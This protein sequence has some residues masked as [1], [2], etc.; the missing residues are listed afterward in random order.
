MLSPLHPLDTA[1]GAVE[2]LALRR[3]RGRRDECAGLHHN[4]DS[5]VRVQGRHA[6]LPERRSAGAQLLGHYFIFFHACGDR[7]LRQIGAFPS[8]RSQVYAHL[9][10]TQLFGSLASGRALNQPSCSAIDSEEEK[11][12]GCT[13]P[14]FAPSPNSP[15]STIEARSRSRRQVGRGELHASEI[16]PGQPESSSS[17]PVLASQT[18]PFRARQSQVSLRCITCPDIRLE[19]TVHDLRFA[20]G[21]GNQ[22]G[23]RTV[24]PFTTE[25]RRGPITTGTS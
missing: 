13:G 19:A 1:A 9:Q 5:V 15:E 25:R 20:S 16:L 8:T 11:R 7:S 14:P 6:E 10:H 2:T 24:P 17:L 12:E 23:L 3:G 4:L 18:P 22:L 21:H